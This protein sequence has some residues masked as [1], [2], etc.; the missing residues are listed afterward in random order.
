M[1]VL[2]GADVSIINTTQTI[3]TVPEGKRFVGNV[4][5]TNRGSALATYRLYFYPVGDSATTNYQFGHTLPLDDATKASSVNNITG[6]VLAEGS[7]IAVN[8]NSTDVNILVN[9]LETV[10]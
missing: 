7:V 5:I 6:I 2:I 8:A 4:M 1:S 10:A 9:G 3:Y